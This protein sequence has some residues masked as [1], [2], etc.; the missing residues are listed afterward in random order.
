MSKLWKKA[1]AALLAAMM[2]VVSLSACG[3]EGE[4][5]SAAESSESQVSSASSAAEEESE[6]SET[7]SG[8]EEEIVTLKV[9][10]FQNAAPD[11]NEFNKVADA[12]NELTRDS[13]GVEVEL[14]RSF[15][16]ETLNLALTSGEKLDLLQ[17]HA[18][19]PGLASMVSTGYV[20]PL[21]DL[22]AEH[23]Q[24]IL[25]LVPESYMKAGNVNGVQYATPNLK[26]TARGAGFAM[27]SDVLDE[28]GIDPDT[29]TTYEDVHDVLVQVRDNYPDLYPL[30]PS[31]SQGGMQ[32]ILPY[33]PLVT[34]TRKEQTQKTRCLWRSAAI[35]Y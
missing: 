6:P 30:V 32:E 10:G 1:A 27:R 2:V 18:Y 23:G 29:I 15:D 28:L 14:F 22:L 24:D 35:C 9:W 34:D 26:D 20:Q 31:W 21:D 7:G 3:G 5:S 8:S 13:I 4:S 19:T 25:D 33:D 16:Y 12:I 17:V 11:T